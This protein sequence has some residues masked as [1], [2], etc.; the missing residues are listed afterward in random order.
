MRK[1]FVMLLLLSMMSSC[2]TLFNRKKTH[3]WMRPIQGNT[4]LVYNK[5]YAGLKTRKGVVQPDAGTLIPL[6][7]KGAC[8]YVER[9]KMKQLPV[10]MIKEG[11][12]KTI[13]VKRIHSA[14]YYANLAHLYPFLAFG[15]LI[16]HNNPNRFGYPRKIYMNMED[17]VSKRYFIADP[18][19]YILHPRPGGYIDLE[20]APPLANLFVFS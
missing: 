20:V 5:D 11:V 14:M 16:D 12:E 19:E 4:Q 18:P 15:F 8:I 1:L 7:R 10:T 9:S 6:S 17:T 3:I 2:V 13:T